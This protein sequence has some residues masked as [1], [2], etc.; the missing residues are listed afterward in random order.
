M[1]NEARVSKN[2]YVEMVSGEGV[3]RNYCVNVVSEEKG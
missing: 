1:V 2:W 3:K